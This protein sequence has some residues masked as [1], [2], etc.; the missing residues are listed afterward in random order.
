MTCIMIMGCAPLAVG[1]APL[2]AVQVWPLDAP[3]RV[4]AAEYR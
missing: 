1:R 2:A 3:R 4:R